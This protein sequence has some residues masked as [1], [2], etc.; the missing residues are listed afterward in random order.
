MTD[1]A[2]P[3]EM[4][5]EKAV[6]SGR[7]WSAKCM[8]RIPSKPERT[9]IYSVKLETLSD[10]YIHQLQN[11]HSAKSQ[12][13]A[14]LPKIICAASDDDLKT[15]LKNQ[16]E[17]TKVQLER[18][19]LLLKRYGAR[20]E[21]LKC[22]GMKS[23]LEECEIMLGV[24]A[25]GAVRDL[26]IISTCQRVEHYEIAGFGTARAYAETLGKAEAPALLAESLDEEAA[27]DDELT[28]IAILLQSQYYDEPDEVPAGEW[29]KPATREK[30]MV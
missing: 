29:K 14:A 19:S 8:E 9:K 20:R 18:L 27:A 2:A 22:K 12:F 15:A 11:L 26:G 10:L 17:V 30:A 28:S 23:L 5:Q 4:R 3:C 1:K 24:M 16:I 13:K 25:T 7:P 21:T 6:G